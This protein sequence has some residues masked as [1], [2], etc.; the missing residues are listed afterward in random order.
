MD[1]L[2][3]QNNFDLVK[4]NR[5][6]EESDKDGNKYIDK[7][8]QYTQDKSEMLQDINNTILMMR[9]VVNIII[10]KLSQKQNP[11]PFILNDNKRIMGLVVLSLFIGGSTLLLSGLMKE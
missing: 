9:I 2:N 4:F 10:D 3:K 8:L 5:N 11:L 1:D 7:P 6:F